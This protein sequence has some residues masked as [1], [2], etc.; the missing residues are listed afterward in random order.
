MVTTCRK[1][2]LRVKVELVS[3]AD[4]QQMPSFCRS[5]GQNAV[6]NIAELVEETAKESISKS[7]GSFVASD[8]VP[9]IDTKSVI[10]TTT[11][12]FTTITTSLGN[13]Q[14][15]KKILCII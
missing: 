11:K 9:V 3:P 8:A 15:L 13:Y 1:S 7:D 6:E 5:L 4:A 12:T 2:S 10:E 14:Q